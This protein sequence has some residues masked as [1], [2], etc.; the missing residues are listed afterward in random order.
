MQETASLTAS[1][2]KYPY[3]IEREG[4]E[5]ICIFKKF[6]LQQKGIFYIS[7]FATIQFSNFWKF[8]VGCIK[9]R[10]NFE[11]PNLFNLTNKEIQS[12]KIQ[13]TYWLKIFHREA[14]FPCH[15]D[16]CAYMRI[17]KIF[18]LFF[19]LFLYTTCSLTDDAWV[20]GPDLAPQK[21]LLSQQFRYLMRCKKYLEQNFLSCLVSEIQLF[22]YI[23]G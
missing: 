9:N 21:F 1:R 5:Y 10:K 17:S 12:G 4:F 23:F 6:H 20:S 2:I 8:K 22:V 3:F 14:E 19:T 7:F 18:L 15:W 13:F 11:I 16:E